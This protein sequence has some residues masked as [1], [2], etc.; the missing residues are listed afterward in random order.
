MLEQLLVQILSC[1]MASSSQRA[2]PRGATDGSEAVSSA[3]I[4]FVA[5]P[6][7]RRTAPIFTATALAHRA[8]P[9]KSTMLS[10]SLLA[11]SYTIPP[12]GNVLNVK[13]FGAK[14]DGTTDDT[15]SIKAAIEHAKLMADYRT[16]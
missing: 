2:Q 16:V 1:E 14:G 4:C 7:R 11:L 3:Q 9:H 6:L 8:G 5:A 15:A 10:L 13:D 12:L